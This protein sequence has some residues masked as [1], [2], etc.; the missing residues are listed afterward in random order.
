LDKANQRKIVPL[1]LKEA[2]E[3][4]WV[5][6]TNR[7][8]TLREMAIESPLVQGKEVRVQVLPLS[9]PPYPPPPAFDSE[10]DT[11]IYDAVGNSVGN[12]KE[13]VNS[14]INTDQNFR[15]HIDKKAVS[16]TE[17]PFDFIINALDELYYVFDLSGI[18][19]RLA[20]L[21]LRG[22][23][24]LETSTVSLNTANYGSASVLHGVGEHMGR[25]IQVTWT[26]QEDGRLM[27]GAYYQMT[28]LMCAGNLD[29]TRCRSI[30]WFC[31]E[32][33]VLRGFLAKW[34]G[35]GNDALKVLLWVAI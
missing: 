18:K 23:C 33:V 26:E 3:S 13:V 24:R 21:V 16:E 11:I 29:F 28:P 22:E 20:Q 15:A 6:Y 17:V 19:H 10:E 5:R 31:R 35:R 32:L 12:V 9:P 2:E 14:V 4:N 7:L 8:A 1:T 27:F 30:R 25:P 34:P